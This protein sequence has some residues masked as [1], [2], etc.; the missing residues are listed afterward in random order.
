MPAPKKKKPAAPS[1]PAR[2]KLLPS[3]SEHEPAPSKRGK[4]KGA[5]GSEE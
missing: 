1:K 4:G 5:D 3:D 2:K